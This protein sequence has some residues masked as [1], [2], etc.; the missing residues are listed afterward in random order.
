MNIN[1]QLA[2][3]PVTGS[4]E[5]LVVHSIFRT[6]QGEGPFTGHRAV[7]IRLAGCNLQCPGCDT[8]YTGGVG[9][10]SVADILTA[11][12]VHADV[13]L[14]VLTG[15]EPF[16]QNCAQLVRELVSSGFTV[17]VE[18]NGTLAPQ[19]ALPPEVVIVC[20]PK[21]RRISK[22]LVAAITCYK[23]VLS[24]TSVDEQD[25]LP[26]VVLGNEVRDKVARPVAGKPVYLQPMDCQDAELNDANLAAC[27]KSCDTYGY[28]LQVQLH[29]LIG[30]A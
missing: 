20:S 5:Q 9:V 6:I 15:G 29:K 10:L 1:I 17:Q 12:K 30:V 28:I 16:R 11:V 25:G 13:K 24:A 3:K 14:I 21:T 23:Y 2:E 7:F 19:E 27:I 18:T 22:S 8:E 4:G 26:L